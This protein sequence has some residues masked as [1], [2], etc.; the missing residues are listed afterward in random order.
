[1][2]YQHRQDG[3]TIPGI[4]TLALTELRNYTDYSWM[5]PGQDDPTVLFRKVKADPVLVPS[6]VEAHIDHAREI[7]YVYFD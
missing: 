7:V 6:V 4:E 5:V 1:M 3:T 2:S